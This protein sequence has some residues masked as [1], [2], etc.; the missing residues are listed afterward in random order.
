MN[1]P[2]YILFVTGIVLFVVSAMSLVASMTEMNYYAS[3]MSMM[4]F[5]LSLVLIATSVHMVRVK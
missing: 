5:L 2:A 3:R 4:I 1:T